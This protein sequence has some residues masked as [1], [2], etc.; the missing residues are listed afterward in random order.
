MCLTRWVRFVNLQLQDA[1]TEVLAMEDMM[2]TIAIPLSEERNARLCNLAQ[3]AGL[4]P[5]E[6]LRQRVD[7]LLSETDSAFNKAADQVLQKNAELYQR[8]A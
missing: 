7:N 3:Q 2:N 4:S 6:F 8:L 1:D 5:E